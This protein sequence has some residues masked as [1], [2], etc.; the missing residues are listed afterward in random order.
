MWALEHGRDARARETRRASSR[1]VSS[2]SLRARSEAGAAARRQRATPRSFSARSSESPRASSSRRV[3]GR[4][5]PH[6]RRAGR[7]HAGGGACHPTWSMG[8]KIT[9][10]SA[11]LANK[12][13]EVIEAHFLFA[14][15]Y[16]RIEV[17]VHPTSI[18]H[19]LVRFRGRGSDRTP[20]LPRHAR[21]DLVRA[22]VSRT[23]RD[24]GAVT[25]SHRRHTRVLRT[26]R[27]DLSDACPR[28]RRRRAAGP[29][30]VPTTLRTKRLS[31]RSSTA[32]SASST[33]AALVEEA[34]GRVEGAPARD[35]DELRE[36]D[37]HA[38][39]LVGGSMG[40]AAAISGS[41]CS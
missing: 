6:A 23:R 13:L 5:V 10:D 19:G 28:S 29:I 15:P 37:R 21:A 24:A 17:V 33:S 14:L 30:R 27:R 18:V 36:A 12:G 40:V 41:P 22:D 20:R 16:D 26:G 32:A 11:T 34:L 31:V 7:R 8:P 38:R 35:L 2:P 25:R 3:A 9:I 1:P 39:E 4:S